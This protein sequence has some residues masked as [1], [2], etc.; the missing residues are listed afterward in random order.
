MGGN[1][2]R[3]RIAGPL[4]PYAAGFLAELETQGYRSNSACDQL[5]LLAH[6]SRWLDHQGSE[7]GDLTSESV[8]E[9]LVTRRIDGYA[10]WLSESGLAPLLTY[11]R[12][13]NVVP[14]PSLAPRTSSEILLD[15]FRN[16]LLEERGLAPRTITSYVSV[17]RLLLG[18]CANPVEMLEHLDA[19]DVMHFVTEQCQMRN[20]SYV[21][22]GLRSF[23][24]YCHLS[25][26]IPAPLSGA[27]PSVA[28]WRLASLPKGFTPD[29]V[30]ALL[31]SCDR[32]TATGVR[33]FAVLTLL[34]RLG[35][36]AGEVAAMQLGDLDWRNAEMVVKGKGARLDY[37]PLPVD[38]GDAL[39][40][41][42]ER[43]GSC[44]HAS[45]FVRMRAPK[46]PLASSGVSAVVF[47]ACRR[48]G[49]PASGAHRLR[50]SAASDMLAAGSNLSE[51]AQVLRHASLATTALYAK[52]DQRTL[53]CVAQP[54]P[55]AS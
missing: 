26:L 3:V 43:R 52:V 9:F 44:A 4:V 30:R 53:L 18:E 33:D 7:V 2:S 37:L 49:L 40:D 8:E 54:W 55:S 16:Y 50:H 51:I 23:L 15:A 13:L 5:R 47:A 19:R 41:W 36:R 45:V 34:A 6:V 10:Q 22:C 29:Q 24:N 14:G 21:A 17:A 31:A 12:A 46:R 48:A 39:A 11:L 1:S 25:G 38:V 27:I 20:A 35:L 42:L 28:S 32:R